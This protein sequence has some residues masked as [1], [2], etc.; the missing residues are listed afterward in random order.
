MLRVMLTVG[1]WS[2]KLAK[3]WE[4]EQEEGCVCV[5]HPKGYGVLLISHTQRP[6]TPVA[7]EEL[8]Q[9]ASAELPGSADLGN[10]RMGDFEGL[11]ASYVEDGERWHRFYLCFGTLLLLI[12]YT[13]EIAH[14]GAEDDAI[15]GML[16]TLRASGN[17]WE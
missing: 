5:T 15:I 17:P 11:H 2:L 1:R 7:R 14:D 12:T 6:K 13:V 4:A 8:E 3:G 9:L 16:R 10:A